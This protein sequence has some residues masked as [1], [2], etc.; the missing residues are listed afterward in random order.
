MANRFELALET[1]EITSKT[2]K[3][4][5]SVASAAFIYDVPLRGATHDD[6]MSLIQSKQL[7]LLPRGLCRLELVVKMRECGI[8]GEEAAGFLEFIAD[9]VC[10]SSVS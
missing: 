7:W 6:L 3:L 1:F 4:L 2:Y 8:C 10:Q 5:L 9:R